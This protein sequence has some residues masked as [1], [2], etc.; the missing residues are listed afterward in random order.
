MREA[1][2][3]DRL[4]ELERGAAS[5]LTTRHHVFLLCL[6]HTQCPLQ[7][8]T[9]QWHESAKT[10]RE[11][12]CGSYLVRVGLPCSPRLAGREPTG[13]GQGPFLGPSTP[14]LPAYDTTRPVPTELPGIFFPGGTQ[15]AAFH[16]TI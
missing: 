5:N 10:Q 3:K 2:S 8:S 7:L 12:K 4:G 1:A 6:R 15:S 14:D 9:P 13:T 11:L 16:V